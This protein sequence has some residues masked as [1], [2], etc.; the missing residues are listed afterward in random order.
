M[1]KFPNTNATLTFRENMWL[2][3][4]KFTWYS[5]EHGKVLGLRLSEERHFERNVQRLWVRSGF[6]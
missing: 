6:E 3:K 2:V 1:R 5:L 4:I